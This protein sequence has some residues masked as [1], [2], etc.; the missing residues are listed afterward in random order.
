M[1][2]RSV[3]NYRSTVS[4]TAT[5]MAYTG[6]INMTNSHMFV[7]LADAVQ[8]KCLQSAKA[9]DITALAPWLLRQ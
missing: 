2:K 7:G 9:S 6:H 5:A 8:S 1:R 3:Y 4:R